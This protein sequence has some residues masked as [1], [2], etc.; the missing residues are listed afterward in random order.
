MHLSFKQAIL[1]KLMNFKEQLFIQMAL[2]N[3][4]TWYIENWKKWKFSQDNNQDNSGKESFV[5]A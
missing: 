1:Q 2:W 3:D 4:S 5:S